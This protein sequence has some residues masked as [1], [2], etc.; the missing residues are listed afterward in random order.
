MSNGSG[1]RGD[2]DR[3]IHN[4]DVE[5]NDQFGLHDLTEDT[6]DEGEE[7]N[8]KRTSFD[9]QPDGSKTFSNN[10]KEPRRPSKVIDRPGILR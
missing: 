3:L 9:G 6:D 7:P 10:L 5:A 2:R 4:Y 1:N 8:H